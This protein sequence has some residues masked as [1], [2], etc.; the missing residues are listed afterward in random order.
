MQNDLTHMCERWIVRVGEHRGRLT[1]LEY[2]R[3]LVFDG[4]QQGMSQMAYGFDSLGP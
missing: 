4:D 1:W 3:Q 2:M